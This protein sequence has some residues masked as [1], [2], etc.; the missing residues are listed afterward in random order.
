[1]AT[2]DIQNLF[3]RFLRIYG[4]QGASTEPT[5]QEPPYQ[6][7]RAPYSPPADAYGSDDAYAPSGGVL[8]GLNSL[9]PGAPSWAQAL[10]GSGG[11]PIGLR[12]PR[13]GGRIGGLPFPP[14]P[15]GPGDV[16]EIPNPHLERLVPQWMR[17]FQTAAT[18]V[19][20]MFRGQL[21]GDG[22][23][24][25]SAEGEDGAWSTES[26][27]GPP[28]NRPGS[29]PPWIVGPAV[30]KE[31]FGRQG[32]TD[33]QNQQ[34]KEIVDPSFRR[35]TRFL[36]SEGD[37]IVSDGSVR[38]AAEEN[39]AKQ[40]AR[41]LADDPLDIPLFLRRQR[42]PESATSQNRQA[43]SPPSNVGGG[44]N[45]GG[46]RGGGGGG[47]RKS[48]E[49]CRREWKRAHEVCVEAFANGTVGDIFKKWKSNYS[50]GPFPKLND[51]PWDVNDCK[52]GFVSEDC[53]GSDYERPPPPKV[54]Q[55]IGRQ[56][57]RQRKASR[58]KQKEKERAIFEEFKRTGKWRFR[59]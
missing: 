2:P 37:Q 19:P 36:G 57:V 47:G 32:R 35:L 6:S 39:P 33:A 23:G 7:P 4:G 49:E 56:L 58:D 25:G 29:Q 51:E 40:P 16:V 17:D 15:T 8:R 9:P 41:P 13:L 50:T 5:R 3:E 11:M 14:M 59:G 12:G 54:A 44:G 21:R 28:A 26:S 34:P 52:K 55:A 20:K 27:S 43:D 18:L 45:S 53:G 24:G 38:P 10:A 22:P 42:E 46:N 30:L 31:K 1:M 48:D